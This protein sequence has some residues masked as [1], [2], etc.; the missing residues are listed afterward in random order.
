MTGQDMLDKMREAPMQPVAQPQREKKRKSKASSQTYGSSNMLAYMGALIG[1]QVGGAVLGKA[2]LRGGAYA[3]PGVNKALL[4]YDAYK[5][6]K[7][8][9]AVK[10]LAGLIPKTAIPASAAGV[11]FPA[12]M[13][14]QKHWGGT[15]KAN[16]T[17]AA[18]DSALA[19]TVMAAPVLRY[20]NT[21]FARSGANP[22]RWQ[23]VRDVTAKGLPFDVGTGMASQPIIN[24]S[25]DRPLA[26]NVIPAGVVSGGLGGAINAASTFA[27]GAMPR[28]RA[29]LPEK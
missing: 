19:G 15:G 2:L 21:P 13:Y 1:S 10:A 24:Y 8:T 20:L 18:V 22:T 27:F 6:L 23:T 28:V 4:A 11:T 25:E 9:K 26:E 16:P 5:M 7:G 17:Q 14:A 29:G 3:V 12:S